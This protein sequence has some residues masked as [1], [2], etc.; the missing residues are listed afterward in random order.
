MLE[1]IENVSKIK[2]N[3]TIPRAEGKTIQQQKASPALPPYPGFWFF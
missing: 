3:E 2:P 1:G